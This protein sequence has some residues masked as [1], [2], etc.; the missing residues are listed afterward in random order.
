MGIPIRKVDICEAH[1]ALEIYR[2]AG[3]SMRENGNP[4]QWKEGYPPLELVLNDI[5]KGNLYGIENGEKLC[6]V[7]VFQ[8]HDCDYD[9][10]ASGAWIGEASYRAIH[11]VAS[12]GSIHKV[13]ENIIKYCKEFKCDLKIDTHAD[14]KIMRH[15][16][17]KNKFVKCGT[18]RFPT[19]EERLAY[20]YVYDGLNC[21]KNA[22]AKH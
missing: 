1:K 11:R 6:A 8:G 21:A 22:P 16:L 18:V 12:D 3:R 15:L 5:E 19:G 7:F 14:N 4:N 10:L 2:I 13:V 17:E 9:K 20:Q